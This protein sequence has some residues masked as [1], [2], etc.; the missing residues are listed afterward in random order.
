[1]ETKLK[2]LLR[3]HGLPTPKFQYVVRD[4]G[5]FVARVDAAYPELRIAIEFDSYE[6]HTGRGALI[7]DTDRRNRLALLN[8]TT[9]TFTADD[10]RRGGGAAIGALKAARD[11]S[12]SVL[13]LP[14]RAYDG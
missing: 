12:R 1:M 7:R 3:S 8:W 2:Q 6:H 13:A 11:R 9:V 5:R 4:G 10:V 14:N